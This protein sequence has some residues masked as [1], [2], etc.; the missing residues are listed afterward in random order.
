[1][2][3]ITC[4]VADGILKR[5]QRLHIKVVLRLIL[6]NQS[7]ILSTL[8]PQNVSLAWYRSV[9]ETADISDCIGV[10]RLTKSKRLPVFFKTCEQHIRS[11]LMPNVSVALTG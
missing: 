10:C 5:P 4:K 3:H 1:M 6:E 9:E 2:H 7:D 8:K 11:Q